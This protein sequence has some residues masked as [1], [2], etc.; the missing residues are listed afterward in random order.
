MKPSKFLLTLLVGCLLGYGFSMLT[1]PKHNFTKFI[2]SGELQIE[3]RPIDLGDPWGFTRHGTL[4]NG[5]DTPVYIFSITDDGGQIAGITQVMAAQKQDKY[6]IPGNLALNLRDLE[7]NVYSALLLAGD[8]L[9]FS[10][11]EEPQGKLHV[12][13]VILDESPRVTKELLV[14][15]TTP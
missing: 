14:E 8:G 10:F 1:T 9:Q 3:S 11:A 15:L 4:G 2:P 6:Y 7:E 13:H 5:L 12:Y